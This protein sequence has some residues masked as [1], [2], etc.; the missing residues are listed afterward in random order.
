MALRML[1]KPRFIRGFTKPVQEPAIEHDAGGSKKWPL[2]PGITGYA[3]LSPCTRYRHTLVRNRKEGKG[4]ILWIGHNPSTAHGRMDDPTIRKEMKFSWANG[5]RHMVKCNIMDYRCTDPKKLFDRL[6][7]DNLPVFSANNIDTILK[8]AKAADAIVLCWGALNA[9]A[10]PHA[11]K[12]IIA[13]ANY[14]SK[15]YCLGRTKQGFPRH[16]LYVK[17]S[18]PFESFL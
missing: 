10:M 17:D 1:P 14:Y 16:P 3:V 12:V 11:H 7:R 6:A 18:T 9:E 8:E 4:T 13:L 5:Y 2:Q 15:I